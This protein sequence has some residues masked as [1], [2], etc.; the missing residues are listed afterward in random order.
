MGPSSSLLGIA[1]AG[2]FLEPCDPRLGC[3]GPFHHPS[4][5]EGSFSYPEVEWPFV[6]V[7]TV[8]GM[9]TTSS[10]A[11]EFA[12]IGLGEGAFFY[13]VSEVLGFV[14]FGIEIQLAWWGAWQIIS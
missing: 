9:L 4:F 5:R 10:N 8:S 6:F 13:R 2:D 11:V 12:F 3:W 1:S 14:G 7:L